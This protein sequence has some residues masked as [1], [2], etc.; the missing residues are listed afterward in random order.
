MNLGFYLGM[1][2]QV[3][4]LRIAMSFFRWVVLTFKVAQWHLE[5]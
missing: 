2:D 1:R 4:S 3:W 5:I